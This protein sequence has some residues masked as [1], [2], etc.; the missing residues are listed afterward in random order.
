MILERYHE[1]QEYVKDVAE[2]SFTLAGIARI[3]IRSLRRNG[4]HFG[5]Q[6]E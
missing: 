6:S 4:G 5:D 1:N 2:L 3:A